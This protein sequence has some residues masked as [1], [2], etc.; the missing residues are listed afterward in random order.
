V[1]SLWLYLV[2]ETKLLQDDRGLEPVGC[3]FSV[4]RDVGLDTHDELLSFVTENSLIVVVEIEDR[5]IV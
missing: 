4:E 2:L 1:H 3:A 5:D